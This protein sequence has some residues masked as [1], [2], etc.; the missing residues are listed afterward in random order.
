MPRRYLTE[1]QEARIRHIQERR[2]QHWQSQVEERLETLGETQTR[3]G[4]VITRHGANLAISDLETGTFYHCLFRQNLC[5]VVCGDQV[6]W[7]PTADGDGV[8]T[9]LL[10]RQ[11]V[12]ARPDYSGREK[13]LAANVTQ[14]V[15]VLAPQPEPSE[16]MID[17]YLATAELI[18]CRALLAINKVDLLSLDQRQALLARFDAYERIGYPLIALTAAQSGGLVPLLPWLE[19]QT[20]IL[21]GQSGVGKSSVIKALLPDMEIQIGQLSQTTRLGRHTTTAAVLYHLAG[22]GHLIDSPGVRSFRLLPMDHQELEWA[23]REFRPFRGQCQFADCRHH[24]EPGCALKA[25]VEEGLIDPRRLENFHHQ[26]REL[27]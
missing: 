6:L 24:H 27:R 14:M 11:S 16:Y 22:G 25:A 18:G 7:Q 20:S 15:L 5:H 21:L 4:R 13:P 10:E 12:L 17:Q 8:V 3:S 26:A 1:R 9:A 19:A 23:Y 2:R